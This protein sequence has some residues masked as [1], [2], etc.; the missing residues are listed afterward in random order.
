M[1]VYVGV[2]SW[3]PHRQ[4]LLEVLSLGEAVVCR[5]ILTME[6]EVTG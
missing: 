6:E 1:H 3:G 5:G 2:L 4:A